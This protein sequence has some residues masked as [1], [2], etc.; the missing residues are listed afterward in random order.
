M[1]QSTSL[2]IMYIFDLLKERICPVC[3]F[4]GEGLQFLPFATAC[5]TPLYDIIQGLEITR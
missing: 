2:W 4:I 5:D 3:Q 1:K